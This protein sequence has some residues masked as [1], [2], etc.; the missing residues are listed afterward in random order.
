MSAEMP[1]TEKNFIH[2]A[3]YFFVDDVVKS[4]EYYRDVLGFSFDRYWGEPPSFAMVW[5][6]GICF[7]LKQCP[8]LARPNS[9]AYGSSTWDAYIWVRDVDALYEEFKTKGVKI[10]RGP[11]V[12]EEYGNKDFDLEDPNGYV[13]CFGQDWS[14][15]G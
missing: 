1:Q 5:R 14:G 4:A 3:Q 7:M 10:I 11:E 15:G 9:I 2:R 6:D 12:V 13:L 8:G